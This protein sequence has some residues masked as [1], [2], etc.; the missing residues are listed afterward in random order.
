LEVPRPDGSSSPVGPMGMSQARNSSAVGVRPTPYVG[1]CASNEAP[2]MASNANGRTLSVPIGHAPVAGNSPRLNAVVQSRHRERFIV[3]F[4]PV[5]GELCARR[6]SLTYFVRAARH[7]LRLAS[8]PVPHEA[9][10][11]M[12][13]A[14][15]CAFELGLAPRLAAVGRH[16]HQLDGAAAGPGQPANL[17]KALA[18]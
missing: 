18:G 8:V 12:R 2:L 1:D 5:L 15:W 3:G 16:F 14:L 9:K 11:R 7:N 6:L 13:H 10:A 17:V 4:V